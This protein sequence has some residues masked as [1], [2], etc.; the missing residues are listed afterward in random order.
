MICEQIQRLGNRCS[1][2]CIDVSALDDFDGLFMNS[3]FNGD[4]SKWDVSNAT[5]MRRMF[6]S[7]AF[8][9][10]L[11]RWNVSNVTAMSTM[12]A[13]SEFNGNIAAWNVSYVRDFRHMFYDGDFQN[14]ISQWLIH[15]NANS[16]DMFSLLQT[17]NHLHASPFH[18]RLAAFDSNLLSPSLKHFYDSNA[19]LLFSIVTDP[20]ER[21]A[22]LHAQW[23]KEQLPKDDVL[24]RFEGSIFDTMPS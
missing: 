16:E 13:L 10:D 21:L 6:K 2:N 22:L 17:K 3:A 4:I 1:L 15:P 9:G 5:T 8:N 12:F 11:S 19:P 7:S 18:W 14:D 24:Q 23:K 20:T